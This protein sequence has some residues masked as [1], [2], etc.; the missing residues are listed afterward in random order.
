MF[1]F[2]ALSIERTCPDLHFILI[3]SCIIEYVTNKRTLNLVKLS[4][5]FELA[6][7][8]SVLKLAVIPVACAHFPTQFLSSSQLCI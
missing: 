1:H 7:L 6:L 4:Q 2:F 8:D 5:V 3:I